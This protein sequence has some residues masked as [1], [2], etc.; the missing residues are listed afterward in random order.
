VEK[1]LNLVDSLSCCRTQE[2]VFHTT[3]LKLIL[4]H[5]G[6]DGEVLDEPVDDG[7]EDGGGDGGEKL[8]SCSNLQLHSL[9]PG[10]LSHPPAG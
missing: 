2:G 8:T 7:E 6:E 5:S 1:G 10:G 4:I 9:V 3:G